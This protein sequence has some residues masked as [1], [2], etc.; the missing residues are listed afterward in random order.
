MMFIYICIY[1]TYRYYIDIMSI[2]FWNMF[3]DSKNQNYFF[4]RVRV[5]DISLLFLFHLLKDVCC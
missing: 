3:Y 1:I 4:L 2:H 5:Y